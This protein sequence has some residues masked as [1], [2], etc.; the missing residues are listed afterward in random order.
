MAKYHINGDGEVKPCRAKMGNC[1]FG[2]ES[3]N[4]NHFG[5][6][7]QA[8]EAAAKK[9]Q[10]NFPSISSNTKTVSPERFSQVKEEIQKALVAYGGV[11]KN[12]DLASVSSTN[13]II[14]KW[15]D[16]DNSSY[17]AFRRLISDDTLKPESKRSVGTLITKGLTVNNSVSI[18]KL[19]KSLDE[20]KFSNSEIDLLDEPVK[21]IDLESITNGSLRAF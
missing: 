5:D 21:G 13:E 1:R 15:F 19:N 9:F 18:D 14:A 16:G 17:K 8:R 10:E 11:Q 6:I 2:G 12:S 3:G 4:D 20:S 7:N